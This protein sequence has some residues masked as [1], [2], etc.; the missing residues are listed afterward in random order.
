MD[1]NFLEGR[2]SRGIYIFSAPLKPG[3]HQFVIYDP[4]SGRVFV[5]ELVI[6]LN[7]EHVQCPELPIV[8]KRMGETKTKYVWLPWHEESSK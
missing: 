8:D 4:P 1:S 3:L 5:K 6:D 2:Q 7:N